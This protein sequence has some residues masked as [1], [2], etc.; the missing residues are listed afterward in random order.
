MNRV[1]A[2]LRRVELFRWQEKS[3]DAKSKAIIV[4]EERVCPIC[5]KRL[6]K[7]VISVFPDGQVVHYGCGSRLNG[8]TGG[9][10][11]ANVDGDLRNTTGS[12]GGASLRN[13][14]R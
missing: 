12:F 8:G 6:G 5:H 1:M 4:G 11:G 2:Q 14:F 10:G 9:K 7:S 13:R 3:I